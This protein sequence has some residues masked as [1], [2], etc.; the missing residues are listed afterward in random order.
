MSSKY[1]EDEKCSDGCVIQVLTN[2]G[3][4]LNGHGSHPHQCVPG[5]NRGIVMKLAVPVEK[6]PGNGEGKGRCQPNMLM[7]GA[8]YGCPVGSF[9]RNFDLQIICKT[10]SL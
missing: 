10:C 9:T 3:R 2:V 4:L 7:K 8:E 5:W 6:H 1:K